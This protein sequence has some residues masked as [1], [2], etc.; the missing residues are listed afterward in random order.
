[1]RPQHAVV[2][3]AQCLALVAAGCYAAISDSGSTGEG[4]AWR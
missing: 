1:M 4:G 3:R 2:M